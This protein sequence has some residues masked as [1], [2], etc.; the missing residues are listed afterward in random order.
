MPKRYTA[1][2]QAENRKAWIKAL[3]SRKYKQ[4]YHQLHYNEEG[5][6]YFCCLGVACDLAAKAGVVEKKVDGVNISYD[7]EPSVMPSSVMNWL[8]LWDSA[9][10]GY[11][12]DNN[13]VTLNDDMD[14]SFR[15]IAT[16]IEKN[17]EQLI[18][19]KRRTKKVVV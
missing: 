13:L 11:E 19:K 4:A 18:V 10:A 14:Y 9:G 17:E 6:D 3:R 16:F 8:G 1:A 7:N 15:K 5:T 2:Q 12:L